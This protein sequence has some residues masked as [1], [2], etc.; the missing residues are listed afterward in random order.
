MANDGNA[1]YLTQQVT[2][3]RYMAKKALPFFMMKK[4]MKEGSKAETAADK[5]MGVKFPPKGKMPAFKKG[6]AVKKG[7]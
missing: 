3:E 6:G 2:Q 7:C 1:E 4:G 5:K